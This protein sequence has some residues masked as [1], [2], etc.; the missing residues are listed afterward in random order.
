MKTKVSSS[1]VI[2][3]LLLSIL[4]SSCNAENED[5]PTESFH[6]IPFISASVVAEHSDSYS[7][8]P[9]ASAT[10]STQSNEAETSTAATT[11]GATTAV[12]ESAQQTIPVTPES[13]DLTDKLDWFMGFEADEFT[14]SVIL[15]H[16]I[17]EKNKQI[18]SSITGDQ[19]QKLFRLLTEETALTQPGLSD[20]DK[21]LNIT[22]GVPSK[23]R[24]TVLYDSSVM[25]RLNHD[26]YISRSKKLLDY[27][28]ELTGIVAYDKA[29]LV[30][31]D[32]ATIRY[33]KD[34]NVLTKE[35][36]SSDTLDHISNL[37]ASAERTMAGDSYNKP[38][39]ELALHTG[40]K[41]ILIDVLIDIGSGDPLS[42]IVV[43]R[44]YWL[45]S[46]EAAE[47]IRSLIQDP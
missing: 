4:I 24:F 23:V 9:T 8:T 31:V 44:Y 26:S 27:I 21:D 45:D 17:K 6:T 42:T 12:T 34:G 33:L 28:Y 2:L 10:A 11:G 47:Y 22:I 25:V 43:N 29:Q 14:V 5:I 1:C 3:I 35:I 41:D 46:K 30:D 40:G 7:F 38:D 32:S 13:V 20:G 18:I 15:A 37:L 39:V 19:Q 36:K 16:T